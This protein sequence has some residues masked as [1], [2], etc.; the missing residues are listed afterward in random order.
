MIALLCST[1]YFV[2]KNYSNEK[3]KIVKLK[4]CDAYTNFTKSDFEWITGPDTD[5][6]SALPLYDG[7]LIYILSG[8]DELPF[9]RYKEKD[10]NYLDFYI[11]DFLLLMNGNIVAI[12]LSENESFMEWLKEIDTKDIHDLRYISVTTYSSEIHL[13]YLK[14]IAG[15]NSDIGLVVAED[16]TDLA[17]IL[18]LFD[19]A[20]IAAGGC[21]FEEKTKKKIAKKK[22]LELL[23]IGEDS[24]DLDILSKL[25]KLEALILIETSQ[26]ENNESL[27]NN[28]NL[29]SLTIM[30]SGIRDISS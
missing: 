4:G 30:K 15:I 22:N 16:I 2:I 12:E 7:D 17:D 21:Q 3:Y 18:D 13:K 10:G 8:N 27:I 29:K 28:K 5:S 1:G 25:P 24:W 20:W 26:P 9:H 23:Y 6:I 14:K 11:D 19:P